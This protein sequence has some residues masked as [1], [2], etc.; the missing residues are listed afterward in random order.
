ML[1]FAL[2]ALGFFL[3]AN[4]LASKAQAAVAVGRVPG[5]ICMC[6]A[7]GRASASRSWWRPSRAQ[8]A[9]AGLAGQ[10]ARWRLGWGAGPSSPHILAYLFGYLRRVQLDD[11]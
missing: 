8:G 3:V 6:G 5:Q 1:A 7:V 4:R 11:A 2:G 9:A 10:G